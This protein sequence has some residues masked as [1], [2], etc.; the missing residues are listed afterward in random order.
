MSQP[1]SGF[2]AIQGIKGLGI[3][4]TGIMPVQNAVQ[5]NASR[6]DFNE[7]LKTAVNSINETQMSADSAIEQLA[8]GQNIELHNVVLATQ[9]ASLTMQ[10]ALQVKNKITEAYQEIMRMQI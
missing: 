6:V 4:E 10:M 8:A 9:K 7:L 5:Q 1:V 2:E 3:P